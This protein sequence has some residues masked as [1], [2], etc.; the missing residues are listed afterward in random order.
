MTRVRP[1]V[2]VLFTAAFLAADPSIAFAKH[3]PAFAR[4]YH[5]TCS[6]CHTA[7]PKLNVLGEAFRLNGYRLPDNGALIKRDAGVPLGD[8]A[9]KDLWPR[10]IWPGE[11]PAIP[12][13]AIGIQSDAVVRRGTGSRSGWA[14]QFPHEVSLLAASTLGDGIS[15]FLEME[16]SQEHGLDATQ[17]RAGFQ[18]PL[19]WLP[20]RAFNLWVGKQNP[21][22]FTFADRIIDQAGRLPF[23]WQEFSIADLRLSDPVRNSELRAPNEFTLTSPHQAIELNG[24]IGGRGYYSVAVGQPASGADED[25]SAPKNFFFKIRYKWGGLRLDGQ[26]DSGAGPRPKGHGQLL[27][28][29]IILEHFG[30]VGS[31]PATAGGNYAYRSFGATVRVLNGPLDAGMGVVRRRDD[32][33]WG[34]GIASAMTSLFGKAEYL[35]LPWLIGSLKVE[36]FDAGSDE[37]RRTGFTRGASESTRIAPGIVALVRQNVRLVLEGELYASERASAEGMRPRPAALW[38]RL[39]VIF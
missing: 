20:R 5:T 4:Q 18:D 11:I 35:V 32:D 30:H 31:A 23:L 13:I 39:D 2:P 36:Q 15:V 24:L 10:A 26:Y 14:L 16:W 34:T 33:P 19:P 17:A 7:A 6:T 28:R 29:A 8:D 27:D 25:D 12:P 1:L 3:I 22:P 21:I 37:A 9:W 38:M